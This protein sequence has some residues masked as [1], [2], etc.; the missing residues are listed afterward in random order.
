[1][2]SKR[3]GYCFGVLPKIFNNFY[4]LKKGGVLR[5]LGIFK[6][7]GGNKLPRL[8]SMALKLKDLWKNPSQVVEV[9]TC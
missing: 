2:T 7:K 1:M 8:V 5:T 3:G 4:T 6:S 9:D